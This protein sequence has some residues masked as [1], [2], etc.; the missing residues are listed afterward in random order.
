MS[1]GHDHCFVLWAD[2]FDETVAVLFVA[3]LR[4]VGLR[5][6]LVGL[7]GPSFVGIHGLVMTP[8]LTLDEALAQGDQMACVVVPC[9]GPA[10]GRVANDPRLQELFDLAA[11]QEA[12]VVVGSEAGVVLSGGRGWVYSQGQGIY[13]QIRRLARQLKPKRQPEM[14]ASR[15]PGWQGMGSIA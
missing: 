2:R 14:A 7:P 1:P 8:D 10:L 13:R 4:R 9:D 12:T 11:A 3:E 6:G 15:Q 5:V